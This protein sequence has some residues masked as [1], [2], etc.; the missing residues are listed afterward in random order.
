MQNDVE[1]NVQNNP[2][3]TKQNYLT[4]DDDFEN[5]TII[6]ISRKIYA[7]RTK[8]VVLIDKLMELENAHN[9]PSCILGF[10]KFK[11]IP[12][13]VIDL[14]EVL[15]E[16]RKIYN[17]TSSIIL[18]KQDKKF[19][20][21]VCDRIIDIKR[22]N[23]NKIHLVPYSKQEDFLEGLYIENNQNCYIINPSKLTEYINNNKE[24]YTGENDKF[25]LNDDKTKLILKKRKEAFEKTHL[26]N[27]NYIQTALYD[28][29]VS[30]SVNNVKY[31][32]NMASV[33]EF[34]KVN[35]S[36]FIKVPS[37]P[38]YIFGLINI[39]GEYIVVLDIRNF[40]TNTKTE[41]KE[42]STI[43]ILNSNEYKIG[44]LADEILESMNLNFDKIIQNKI[45]KQDDS[46]LSEFVH[47]DEI[48]Q[49][50]DVE[51]LLK[52]DRLTL[53]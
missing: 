23:K 22:L 21:I 10:V 53:C 34:Y 3:T 45:Q 8:R 26:T 44:I 15:K 42:K 9:L 28:M 4:T 50:V 32:I 49:I 13:G 43:I 12:I 1:L 51:K 27:H 46:R 16:E 40:Y 30:F 17:T 7:I 38:E 47:M 20:A 31:Y 24:K 19:S 25:I 14:R 48:Y 29:G 18:M 37:T 2:I 35:N 36:K 11:Q 39:K 6:E 41:I 5:Y 33:K 52:D